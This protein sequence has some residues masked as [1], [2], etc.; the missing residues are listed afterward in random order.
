MN[1]HLLVVN[2]FINLLHN[3]MQESVCGFTDRISL[4]CLM[5]ISSHFLSPGGV[6]ELFYLFVFFIYNI[7]LFAFY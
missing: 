4:N 1:M 7:V 6:C 2:C 5:F 3:Q